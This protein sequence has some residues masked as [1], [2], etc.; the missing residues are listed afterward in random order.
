MKL[1]FDDDKSIHLLSLST[2]IWAKQLQPWNW[3]C[4]QI[5]QLFLS[6][7]N[8]NT[9]FQI[10]M[11]KFIINMFVFLIVIN[12]KLNFLINLFSTPCTIYRHDPGSQYNTKLYKILWVS[13]SQTSTNEL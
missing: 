3:K 1:C 9:V 8:F 12:Q 7:N 5:K 13:Q 11:E 6:Y 4:S 10:S 2:E